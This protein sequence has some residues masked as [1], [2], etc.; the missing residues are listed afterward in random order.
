M[1]FRSVSGPRVQPE[2]DSRSAAHS[3][4]TQSETP[5]Q[6]INSVIQSF[7]W[8]DM[9]TSGIVV[10]ITRNL[11]RNQGI[12]MNRFMRIIACGS[13]RERSTEF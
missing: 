9:N 10:A 4:R 7:N 5:T 8:W 11:G 3:I 1:D 6:Y 2:C 13:Q 12:T